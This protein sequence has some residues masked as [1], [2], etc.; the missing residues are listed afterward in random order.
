MRRAQREFDPVVAA[1][2]SEQSTGIAEG[3]G[4]GIN[5]QQGVLVR[6]IVLAEGDGAPLAAT[7][8]D[9]GIAIAHG[10]LERR[11]VGDGDFAFGLGDEGEIAGGCPDLTGRAEAKDRLVAFDFD[12][13]LVALIVADHRDMRPAVELEVLADD[14]EVNARWRALRRVGCAGGRHRRSRRSLRGDRRLGLTG[15]HFSL[16]R[17]VF[18][19][20]RL[21]RR[22]RLR[23]LQ[24]IDRPLEPID[25][26]LKRPN[27]GICRLSQGGTTHW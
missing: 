13:A 18:G 25:L 7:E 9:E 15:L 26:I 12:A 11:A 1:G 3:V 5:R 10:V 20:F 22:L 24:F 17:P 14:V 23:R 6:R 8:A 27:L 16:C 4:E 21:G 2:V 19:R